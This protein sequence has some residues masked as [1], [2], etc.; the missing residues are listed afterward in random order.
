MSIARTL[1][2]TL[3]TT[4]M[5]SSAFAEGTEYPLTIPNCGQEVT[6]NSAPGSA[7]AIGQAGTE[8]L[9]AL[10]LGDKVA[11]TGVWFNE[12]LPEFKEVNDK[13]ERLADNDP[14]FESIVEK[15]PGLVT[16]EF[17]WHIGPEGIIATR[18]QFHELSIPTY[19][20]PSDCVGKDNTEGIDGTRQEAFS[21]D[22]IYQ[23]I[24]ELAE[25][26]DVKEKGDELIADMRARETAAVEK[27]K[28]SKIEDASAVL[29]ISSA[30]L[31]IDPWV[32]GGMGVPNYMLEQVGIDNIVD[33]A[34][35][36][37]VVGWETIAKANPT[38]IIIGRM[39][40]RRFP[41][42]DYEEKLKFL[43]SDPVTSQMDAVK[44]DR[45]IVLDTM[46]FSATTRLISGL[47]ALTDALE[48][49]GVDG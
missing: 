2:I 15:K 43:K 46:G 21:T 39:D 22:V 49:F 25:I 10:G 23:G 17:E 35:E 48:D 28:S 9:Y 41:A 45:I 16:V 20:L 38:F 5:A 34:E 4:L 12:V 8:M 24:G 11:G 29:W 36:W 42:D 6:F 14:S 1:S 32:A 31:E 26:F 19:V 44:S 37:P 18:D 7:V 13:V 47:E 27:A 40:R 3:A 33:T 30:D